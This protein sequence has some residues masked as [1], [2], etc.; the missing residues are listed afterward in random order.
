VSLAG[1]TAL[2]Y[3]VEAPVRDWFQRW[4][5]RRRAMA[6]AIQGAGT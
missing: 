6:P 2:H 5:K 1:A 3:A 4:S